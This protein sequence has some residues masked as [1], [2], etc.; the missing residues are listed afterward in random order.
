MEYYENRPDLV[1]YRS[2]RFIPKKPSVSARDYT[3]KD[4]F[5]GE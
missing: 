4:N 3:F 1:I 5:V 2:I